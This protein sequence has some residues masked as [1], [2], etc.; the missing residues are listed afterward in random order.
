MSTLKS[1]RKDIDDVVENIVDQELT[2][3]L[4]ESFNR[5]AKAVITD[6]AIPDVRDGLKPVQRRIIYAMYS[7]HFTFD[8]ETVKSATVVGEVI[9]KYHP[10]GDSSIYDAMVRL[11]QNWKMN[12]PLI[13]FQGNNGS[14][15]N[16]PAA[17]YR[18]T[19]A[20]LSQ[21]SNYMTQDIDKDTVDMCY[22]FDDKHYE[23]TVLPSRIPNLLVNGSQGIAIGSSTNIPTHNLNEIIDAVIYRIEHKRATVDDLFQFVKGPDFPTGGIIDDVEA[24]TNI[25]RTGQGSFSIHSKVEIDEKNNRLVITEIPYGAI[26]SQFV[27]DLDEKRIKDKID[28][29]EEIRDESTED[30]KIVIDIK[31]NANPKDV[32]NYLNSKGLLKQTFSTNMLAIN[33]GHPQTMNLIQIIDSYIEHQQDVITR[34]SQYQKKK[35]EL[36]LNVVLG[37]IRAISIL[38]DIIL[39]IRQSSGKADSKQKL[40]EK[41]HFNE[42]Q[43]EAI[44]TLQLYRLSNTDVQILE[45]ERSELMNDIQYLE[46]I[47]ADIEK[48][49]KVIVK[50]LKEIN[51]NFI[52][53]RRTTIRSEKF[54][55]EQ[56]DTTKLIAKEDCY[57]VLTK[58]G[59]IK[60]TSLIS[61]QKSITD[62][63]LDS[64][65]KIKTNDVIKLLQ[66]TDTHNS[67][68]A[69][70][71]KGNYI[72]IPIYAIP[73]I[74][75]K[76]EGKH[77]NNIITI[78][79]QDKIVKAY[80]IN[81]FKDGLN[82]VIL[83]AKNKIKR[84]KLIDFQTTKITSKPINCCNLI[85]DD[86][87]VSASISSGDDDIIVIN[88]IGKGAR[89]NEN[90]IPIVGLKASGVKAMELN[91]KICDLVSLVVSE[92]NTSYPILLLTDKR[93]ARIFKN[94][95]IELTQKRPG[96][97]ISFISVSLS[98]KMKVVSLTSQKDFR[99]NKE[100]LIVTNDQTRL[101]DLSNLEYSI[102]NITM[103]SNILKNEDK[104]NVVDVH[105]F[106]QIINEDTLIYTP[107]IKLEDPKPQQEKT[108]SLFESIDLFFQ[109]DL[110]KKKK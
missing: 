12:V 62:D 81:E 71:S 42:P 22:T 46:S 9:G 75:W 74:K 52:F 48:L 105:D 80:V 66:K 44:V 96:P 88:E 50:D 59:Y 15:D 61:Y 104:L 77:L 87:V 7:R 3:S 57:V 30:V 45:R 1:K 26:K 85:S 101:V 60:R 99:N 21:M 67:I 29:I 63:K 89:Y 100:I 95:T 27:H 19:E 16:D 41:Y 64:L 37:L 8:K 94:E 109:E 107:S 106:S 110:N 20:K 51:K 47:L 86:K 93:C 98:N 10:H 49:N 65:P 78:D 13:T 36:R 18:Y 72:Y 84:T 68:L 76:E 40:I 53:E 4:C 82:V 108:K 83:T 73:E 43:A 91:T 17:A 97:V 54:K 31:K 55:V 102:T 25:Y 34:R 35:D 5:Y 90:L 24:I 39:L 79:A 92:K 28:N 11:S 23:P 58:D 33:K 103:K 69:F 56:V 70:T 38:D 2:S 32:L 14:I 6:R